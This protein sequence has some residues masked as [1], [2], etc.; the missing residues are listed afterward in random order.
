MVSPCAA[1]STQPFRPKVFRT[2]SVLYYAPISQYHRWQANL[3]VL[4]VKAI[5]SVP[6][7]LLSHTFIERLIGT[8]HHEYLNNALY[9]NADDL[10]RKLEE[11]RH[12]YNSHL[13]VANY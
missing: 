11:F 10:E 1:C 8:I 13:W 3:R 12:Y 5:K 7:V 2:T 6:Y 9:W 4:D